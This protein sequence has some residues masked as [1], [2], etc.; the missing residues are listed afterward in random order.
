LACAA[1]TF[2]A[3]SATAC[4]NG[5]TND[6]RRAIHAWLTCDD[7]ASGQRA[8][9][10]VLGDRAVPELSD[11]LKSPGVD[12]R[13]IMSGKFDSSFSRAGIGSR[14]PTLSSAAYTT[15]RNANYVANYQKRAA[16]SLGDIGTDAAKTALDGA[17]GDSINRKYRSDVVRV[18]KFARSRF[19]APTYAGR[20][21]PYRL[22]FADTVRVVAPLTQHFGAQA[23]VVIEDSLFPAAELPIER[24][25]DSIRF[26]SVAATGVH[27]VSVL[28]SPNAA[29]D[30]IAMFVTTVADVTDRFPPPCHPPSIGCLVTNALPVPVIP[31]SSAQQKPV[32]PG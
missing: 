31:A 6:D 3:L 27:M 24:F 11:A 1:L 5:L 10:E 28:A 29:P 16:T 4:D 26:L 9:V 8:A 15:F 19:D 21:M 20:I 12:Q 22:G 2:A 13:T 23:S 25:P 32:T 17:I 7:C 18:I 14:V 30:K